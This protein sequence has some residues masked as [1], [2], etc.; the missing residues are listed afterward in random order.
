MEERGQI[1]L[2]EDEEM[3]YSG[4]I[5]TT[6]T[7]KRE[8]KAADKKVAFTKFKTFNTAAV[9]KKD[10]FKQM[11]Q[12]FI[13]E[14]AQE[15]AFAISYHTQ[16]NV[17]EVP[18]TAPVEPVSAAPRKNSDWTPQASAPQVQTSSAPFVPSLTAPEFDPSQSFN[19]TKS[20]PFTMPA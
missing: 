10:G 2:A 7:S 12:S 19:M 17:A 20:Q 16:K 14:V 6:T 8:A 13:N 15:K 4:V 9:V 5:R 11:T 3:L 18:P 1:E